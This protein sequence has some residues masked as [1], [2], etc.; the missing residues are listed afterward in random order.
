MRQE[1]N[2]EENATKNEALREFW[3]HQLRK[4]FNGQRQ[5][6]LTASS[7]R[8]VNANSEQAEMS[9]RDLEPA[10]YTVQLR[11]TILSTL[12]IRLS[13]YVLKCYLF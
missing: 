11:K 1:R 7:S 5:K 2:D 12:P 6:W 9:N 8:N 3:I 13:P 4:G 10:A